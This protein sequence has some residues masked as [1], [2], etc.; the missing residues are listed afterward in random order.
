MY[1]CIQCAVITFVPCYPP[2]PLPLTLNPLFPRSLF[3][4]HVFSFVVLV[5]Y[6]VSLGLVP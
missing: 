5:N 6:V 4:L 2:L 1:T 3:Y